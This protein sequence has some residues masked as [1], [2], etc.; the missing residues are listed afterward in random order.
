L[1]RESEKADE[2][3]CA[4]IS[5]D[6]SGTYASA[7]QAREVVDFPVHIVDTRQTSWALGHV[8][9]SAAEARDADASPAEIV[10]AV[11]SSMT[12]NYL[13]FTVDSLEYLHRGGRIGNASRWLGTAL[14]IKPVLELR[15][16]V[17]STVDK[18]RTRRRAIDH[19]VK[20]AEIS[21][22]NRGVKR[23]SVI[24]GECLDDAQVLMDMASGRLKPAET[25]LSYACAVLGV[26]VGP[27]ALGIIVEAVD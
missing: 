14:N 22:G 9:L 1:A 7:V 18:V 15:E 12:R 20:V 27:G 6:L 8:M 13:A 4:V 21:V 5:S 2:I 17:I 23:L 11:K 24:H 25:Y 3:V 10:E 19:L 16:G 26:H